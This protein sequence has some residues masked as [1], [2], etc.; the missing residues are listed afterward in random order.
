MCA[1][2]KHLICMAFCEVNSLVSSPGTRRVP[3]NTSFHK[4]CFRKCIFYLVL[5]LWTLSFRFRVQD[6]SRG[7][8]NNSTNSI[9][10]FT[11]Y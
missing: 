2:H 9:T 4:S 8:L 11:Y 6:L 1:S 3:G 7:G 10:R 5:V